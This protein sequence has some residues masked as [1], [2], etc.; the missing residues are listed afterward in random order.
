[1]S[2]KSAVLYDQL[3]EEQEK[4]LAT[5]YSQKWEVLR[6]RGSAGLTSSDY[7]MLCAM[8]K[9]P[10]KKQ[11]S[12]FEAEDS[13]PRVANMFCN[14]LN[15]CKTVD[16]EEELRYVSLWLKVLLASKPA[17]GARFFELKQNP[18]KPM[19][20]ILYRPYKNYLNEIKAN[21]CVS[22]SIMIGADV[23]VSSEN[24]EVKKFG[25]CLTDALSELA[26]KDNS[27]EY[28][29]ESMATALKNCFKNPLML[30]YIYGD[31]SATW[32]NFADM[33]NK[34][35]QNQTSFQVLYLQGFA[36]LLVA[37]K[38]DS[39]QRERMESHANLCKTMINLIA[40]A[41]KEKVRRIYLQVIG[42]LSE[43][44]NFAEMCVM[45]GLY[46]T[47][48]RLSEENFKD[49]D[50]PSIVEGLMTK[51]RPH[52]R[53][54]SSMERYE[55]ELKTKTLEMGPVHSEK[56][57]KKNYMKFEK[58]D[59]QLIKD[60]T[61]LLDSQDANTVKVAA[62]DIGEFARLYPDGRRIVSKFGA[63]NK[64]F[65][66]LDKCEDE[67]QRK[68]VLLATQKILVVSWQNIE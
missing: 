44:P 43:V 17:L 59:F 27:D 31:R 33:M 49:D 2:S 11:F 1:M 23:K 53:V 26:R 62:Y 9:A 18:V 41:R 66:I 48:T 7:D 67:D 42:C 61:A 65:S 58:N 57:W 63:K 51:L 25:L 16:K 22:A 14:L 45:Y 32:Q 12:L 37:L 3:T 52:V 55:K 36:L 13:G 10:L 6:D 47:L 28:Y 19:V 29:V 8:D 38:S 56:F 35:I 60:L 30:E 50:I 21:I 24:M 40:S 34:F 5:D 64:L 54:M 46:A 20:D 4:V 68:Q 15:L 39:Y